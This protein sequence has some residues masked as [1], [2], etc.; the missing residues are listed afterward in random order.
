MT[1]TNTLLFSNPGLIDVTSITTMGVS[2][3]PPNS[4]GRFGTGLKYSIANILRNGGSITILS[5]KDH[6]TFSTLEKVIRGKSFS[7]VT[8]NDVPLGFT[9]ELGKHWEPWMVLRELWCNAKDEGGKTEILPLGETFFPPK[10]DETHILVEWD[11]L[12]EVWNNRD[13][14]I[15]T[16]AP[17][18]EGPFLEV[19]FGE[20]NFVFHH[21]VRVFE[22]H[23]KFLNRYNIRQELFLTEDRT[24]S[25]S[26]QILN[27]LRDFFLQTNE[28]ELLKEV[29]LADEGFVERE[30]NFKDAW[31]VQP[32]TTFLQVCSSLRSNRKLSP[33]ARAVLD[34]HTRK[35][36][37]STQTYSTYQGVADSLTI[38]KEAIEADYPSISDKFELF[39]IVFV[40]NLMDDLPGLLEDDRLYLPKATIEAGPRAIAKELISAA[41]YYANVSESEFLISALIEG[42]NHLPFRRILDTSPSEEPSKDAP[43]SEV[44]ISPREII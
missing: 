13:D 42:C 9:T 25:S 44:N 38:A 34:R 33:S 36:L 20:T 29:L 6:Y 24:V 4:F 26:W 41:A 10:S 2:V 43:P 5:G 17:S 3:K 35:S 28:V 23:L 27:I 7:I 1:R 12:L 40:E 18:Y 30:I 19:F 15:L 16:D 21:G 39:E 31:S 11:D 22:S 8:M 14:V 37:Q 32:S